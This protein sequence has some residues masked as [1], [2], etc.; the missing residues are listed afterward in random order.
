MKIQDIVKKSKSD[1]MDLL[2]KK[3]E[4]LRKNNFSVRSG[5]VKNIKIIS[6]N[7]KDIARILTVLKNK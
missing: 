3:R 4:E 1:L 6:E 7:R 5:K 2:S